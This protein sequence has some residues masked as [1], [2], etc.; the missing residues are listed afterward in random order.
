MNI[1]CK[2][3]TLEDGTIIYTKQNFNLDEYDITEKDN[4]I[5]FTPKMK[6][7][8]IDKVIENIED[9]GFE[10]GYFT[11]SKIID[12]N[13]NGEKSLNNMYQSIIKNVHKIIGNGRK[14]IKTSCLHIETKNIKTKGFCYDEDL[15]IGFQGVDANK[16]FLE[17]AKQC[18][19]NKIT[20]NI[21]IKF[22]DGKTI[23]FEIL[24]K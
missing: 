14:V 22:V 18:F 24:H 23:C 11:E 9:L 16:A 15:G 7:I 19:T 8:K 10:K 1:Y 20:L 4:K 3:K 5:I 12:C 2:G 13:I 21:K 6:I 17:I